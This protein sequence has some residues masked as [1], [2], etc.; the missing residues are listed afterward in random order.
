MPPHYRR[1]SLVERRRP[2]PN[3]SLAEGIAELLRTYADLDS[4]SSRRTRK[5]VPPRG[6]RAS[7]PHDGRGRRVSAV[8]PRQD[9]QL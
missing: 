8:L 2:G 3:A 4:R 1:P 7:L 6:T 9:L 5:R